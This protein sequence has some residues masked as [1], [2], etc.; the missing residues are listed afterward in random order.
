MADFEKV[1][2]RFESTLVAF[3]RFLEIHGLG[4][5]SI[6]N[7]L[8]ADRTGLTDT[9]EGYAASIQYAL[10]ALYSF[11]ERYGNK[12]T[13][14]IALG[15][16]QPSRVIEQANHQVPITIVAHDPKVISRLSSWGWTPGM[17]PS[18]TAPVWHMSAFR[19][20]FLN[21]FDH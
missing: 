20:H 19:N 17:L 15:D 11:V 9:Q 3:S 5:G 14:L 12:N 4:D 1:G 13:V 2:K 21:A 16:H 10:R 7:R 6:F 8:P 18:S